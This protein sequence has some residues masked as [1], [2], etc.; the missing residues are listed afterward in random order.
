MFGN[1]ELLKIDRC[2]DEKK[3]KEKKKKKKG[4]GWVAVAARQWPGGSGRVAKTHRFGEPGD[5]GARG[6]GDMAAVF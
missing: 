2:R 6:M 5:G 3:K 4:S 1:E